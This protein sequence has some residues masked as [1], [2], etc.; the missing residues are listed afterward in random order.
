MVWSNAGLC[1][2]AARAQPVLTLQRHDFEIMM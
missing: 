2:H 1:I